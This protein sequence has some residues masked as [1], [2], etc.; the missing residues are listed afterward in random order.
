M[1]GVV[2]QTEIN[3]KCEFTFGLVQVTRS[4]TEP[5]ILRSP[6]QRPVEA[7]K[8]R[9]VVTMDTVFVCFS[10]ADGAVAS[11]WCT[12]YLLLYCFFSEI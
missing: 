8:Q 3:T 12:F 9:N 2:Q 6:K 7:K 11:T 10:L 5:E 1:Y 4:M